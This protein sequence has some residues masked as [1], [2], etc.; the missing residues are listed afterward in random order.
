M[1]P[2]GQLYV[3]V[4]FSSES[5]F[6]A[7]IQIDRVQ[8]LWAQCR[9][10]HADEGPWLFG[11]WSIA[12]AFCAPLVIRFHGYSVPLSAEASRYSQTA[13]EQPHL[14]QWLQLAD[15]ESTAALGAG[16]ARH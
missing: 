7:G 4:A 2:V 1:P 10:R 6:N 8:T 16:G 14:Q 11:D 13:F 3:D 5:H 12:D 15:E 9:Q